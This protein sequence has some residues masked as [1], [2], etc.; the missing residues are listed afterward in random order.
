MGSKKKRKK[1][2]INKKS[3]IDTVL[4][5]FAYH[6]FENFNFKQVSHALNIHD[7]PSRDLVKEMLS[8]LVNMGAIIAVKR[9]KYK[10][11]P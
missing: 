3:F 6:P 1:Q 2:A 9:G 8:K 10:L 7:K 11:N 4:S 5:V